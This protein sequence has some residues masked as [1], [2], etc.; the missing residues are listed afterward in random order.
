MRIL[1][2]PITALFTTVRLT[3]VPMR[4]D[5]LTIRINRMVFVGGGDERKTNNAT[6]ANTHTIISPTPPHATEPPKQS[7]LAKLGISR[8]GCSRCAPVTKSDDPLDF[9]DRD[10]P[11]SKV[12]AAES[13]SSHHLV[14][15]KDNQVDHSLR[16]SA[17]QARQI[18]PMGSRL[19]ASRLRRR[20]RD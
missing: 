11:R 13:T 7:G 3:G 15:N 5:L 17:T 16:Q 8:K 18:R 2:R 4:D 1:D 9:T 10:D 6:Q 20:R 12:R 19:G 14:G